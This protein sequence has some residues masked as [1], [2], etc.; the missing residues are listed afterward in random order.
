VGR[1]LLE[2]LGRQAF[3]RL[4]RPHLDLLALRIF[5]AGGDSNAARNVGVPVNRV[6]ISLFM[7]TAFCAAV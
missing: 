3:R 5:A 7:F 2:H 4:D 1:K 6:K